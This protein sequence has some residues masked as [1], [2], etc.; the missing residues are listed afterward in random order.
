MKSV[1]FILVNFSQ[2]IFINYFSRAI[3]AQPLSDSPS[4]GERNEI[5]ENWKLL[6]KKVRQYID[7]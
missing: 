2:T 1:D 5:M 3:I 4:V 6:L 7:T